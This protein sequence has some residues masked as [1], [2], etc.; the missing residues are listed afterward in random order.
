MNGAGCTSGG[1]SEGV[2][3]TASHQWN[4]SMKPDLTTTWIE[5]TIN[6]IRG[7]NP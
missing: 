5:H 1:E 4:Y 6:K 3:R 2:Y 7:V